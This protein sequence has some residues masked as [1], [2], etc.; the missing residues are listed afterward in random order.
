MLP[1]PIVVRKENGEDRILMVGEEM[2]I[3]SEGFVKLNAD[4]TGFYLTSYDDDYY[5]NLEKVISGFSDLDRSDLIRSAYMFLIQG[6]LDADAYL[7]IINT[8]CDSPINPALNM[9]TVDLGMITSIVP[10][11]EI[12]KMNAI[13]YLHRMRILLGEKN[14]VMDSCFFSSCS[15]TIRNISL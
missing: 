10:E 2:S 6:K 14:A 4:A 11:D 1:V 12:F 13:K 9:I 15:L 3:L 8:A 7:N 5:R